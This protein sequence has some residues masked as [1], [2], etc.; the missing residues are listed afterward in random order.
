MVDFVLFWQKN[1]GRNDTGWNKKI[2]FLCRASISRVKWTPLFYTKVQQATIF[3]CQWLHHSL[4]YYEKK[5]FLR[6]NWLQV[7]AWVSGMDAWSISLPPTKEW[8]G[9]LQ[10]KDRYF[11]KSIKKG[12]KNRFEHGNKLMGFFVVW[13]CPCL[14]ATHGQNK[15]KIYSLTLS[16]EIMEKGVV[17]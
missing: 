5:Y 8:S 9:Q 10:Q 6:E 17:Y 12:F 7:S 15:N 14:V 16:L 13:S 11:I 3:F 2:L 4:W 1:S